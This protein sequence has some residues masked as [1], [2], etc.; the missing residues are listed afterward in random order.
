MATA[1][2]EDCRS[3]C[4][5]A[6]QQAEGLLSRVA[7]HC[8]AAPL[9]KS[10]STPNRGW[11]CTDRQQKHSE[12]RSCQYKSKQVLTGFMFCFFVFFILWFVVRV[13]VRPQVFET[14]L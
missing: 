6:V 5:S 9:T 2:K 13:A 8:A 4:C 10:C 1:V 7:A 14:R 3:Q 12:E 11:R